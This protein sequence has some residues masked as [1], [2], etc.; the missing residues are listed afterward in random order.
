MY[1]R[2]FFHGMRVIIIFFLMLQKNV[3]F[4]LMVGP[5]EYFEGGAVKIYIRLLEQSRQSVQNR[6]KLQILHNFTQFCSKTTYINLFKTL[7]IC[8]IATVT[9]HICTVTVTLYMIILFYFSL[10]SLALSDSLSP[11]LQCQEEEAE[12]DHQNPSLPPP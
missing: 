10:L 2:F 8:K 1:S 5:K 4:F 3:F 12:A 7:F 6:K 11:T 9:V